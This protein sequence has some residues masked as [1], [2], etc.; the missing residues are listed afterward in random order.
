LLDSLLPEVCISFAKEIV[1][2]IAKRIA[3]RIAKRGVSAALMFLKRGQHHVVQACGPP[4][5]GLPG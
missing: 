1:K 4:S 3:N 5:S 2:R